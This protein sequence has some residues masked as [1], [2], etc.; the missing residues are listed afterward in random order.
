V[1][2]HIPK[3]ILPITEFKGSTKIQIL[4]NAITGA[5]ENGTFNSGDA[6]PS[7]NELSR[8]SGYSRDTVV[9]AYRL[10]RER[11]LVES[12]PAKGIFVTGKS[13]RIFMLLDDFSAFK[14]QLYQAFRANIPGT[15]TVDLLF[16]H[17]NEGV[18]EQLVMNAAGRYSMYIIM[19]ISNRSIHPV[20]KKINPSRLLLLDMGTTQRP[21]ISYLLQNFDNAVTGCLEKSLP[22]LRKYHEIIMI[23]SRQKTPHPS[24]TADAVSHFCKQNGFGFTLLPGFDI[25]RF[26]K[27]QM[28]LVI[29]ENDLV[30]IVKASRD[31]NFRPGSEIGILAY[32]ETPMKEI[33]ANGISTISVNFT[34][35]GIKAADFVVNKQKIQEI[36]PTSLIIRNSL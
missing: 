25:L 15:W 16:H 5:I 23:Y 4:L 12:V 26:R 9:K 29:K 11:S 21:E 34:E 31:R 18:Y 33:A 24:E 27:G 28:Y 10:L 7:V 36:L 32:N 17:Y 6:L 19:N 3:P 2:K 22:L 14:E 35:M 13:Q 30:D 1:K 20:L 8:Q